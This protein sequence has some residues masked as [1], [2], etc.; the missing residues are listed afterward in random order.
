M[1]DRPLT[2]SRFSQAWRKRTTVPYTRAISR[3]CQSFSQRPE[4]PSDF[5]I[6]PLV[7]SS[8]LLCRISDYFSYDDIESSDI[9]SETVLKLSVNN[10]SAELQ[11][12]RDATPQ[13]VRNNSK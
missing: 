13:S 8:E 1:L 12:L 9:N 2:T 10:F 4:Y 6:A 7:Q 5:L 3:A 11:R